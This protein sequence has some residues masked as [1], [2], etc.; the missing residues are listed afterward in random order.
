MMFSVFSEIG[1]FNTDPE[2]LFAVPPEGT[3]GL[4]FLITKDQ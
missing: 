3:F 1:F 4:Q 2:G